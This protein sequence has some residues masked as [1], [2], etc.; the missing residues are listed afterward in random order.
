MVE[1]QQP[2]IGSYAQKTI[3]TESD[4]DILVEHR[5]PGEIVVDESDVISDLEKSSLVVEELLELIETRF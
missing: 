2:P 1:A 3:K 4:I 5:Y